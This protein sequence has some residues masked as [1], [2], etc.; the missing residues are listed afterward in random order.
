MI[1]DTNVAVYDRTA[2]LLNVNAIRSHRFQQPPINLDYLRKSVRVF[3][4]Q[5]CVSFY[6]PSSV[7]K[8]HFSILYAF[9]T[10]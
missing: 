8:H 4:L 5:L 6:R 2:E 1:S 9:S 10:E 3:Y 7:L